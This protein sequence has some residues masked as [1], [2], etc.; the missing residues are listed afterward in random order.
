MDDD[1]QTNV[2]GVFA[3]GDCTAAIKQVAV[4]A[5]Q[6]AVAGLAAIRYVRQMK[7]A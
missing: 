3:A 5:G 2:P 7:K 1:Q 6:G 4:A